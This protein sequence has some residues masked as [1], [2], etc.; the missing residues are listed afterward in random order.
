MPRWLPTLSATTAKKSEL[1]IM[2]HD[3]SITIDGKNVALPIL[4]ASAGLDVVDVRGLINEGLFTFD[5]GFLSTASCES[6]LPISMV[7]LESLPIVAIPSRRWRTAQSIWKFAIYYCTGSCR[8]N[9]HW[10]SSKVKSMRECRSTANSHK[11]LRDSLHPH[12][13]CPCSAQVLAG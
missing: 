5:P 9:R 10:I 11:F 8:P 2:K 12:I 1:K 4:E 13:R 3:V 6:K 7:M